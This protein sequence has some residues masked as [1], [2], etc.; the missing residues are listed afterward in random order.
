VKLFRNCRYQV[1][2]HAPNNSLWSH[3]HSY[4]AAYRSFREAV[5]NKRG[6]HTVGTRV[7]LRDVGDGREQIL[8]QGV[9]QA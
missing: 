1:H 7:D 5:N 2:V 8:E 4:E 3:H 9:V 6:D